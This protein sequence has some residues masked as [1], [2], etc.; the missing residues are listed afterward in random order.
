MK[1]TLTVLDTISTRSI[2]WSIEN[3]GYEA[4]AIAAKKIASGET[5]KFECYNRRN[6]DDITE[7]TFE[8]TIFFGI[9]EINGHNAVRISKTKDLLE[10]QTHSLI[11]SYNKYVSDPVFIAASLM[12][13]LRTQYVD[14]FLKEI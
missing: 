13:Y 7:M 8:A 10:S 9:A 3:H 4:V 6:K 1:K 12:G 5:V 2:D 11:P 14:F